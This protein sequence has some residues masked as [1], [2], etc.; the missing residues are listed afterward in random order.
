MDKWKVVRI[1][2]YK[3]IDIVKSEVASLKYYFV[4]GGTKAEFIGE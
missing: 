4:K 2:V 3:I 1:F